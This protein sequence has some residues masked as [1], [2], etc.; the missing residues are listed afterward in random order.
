MDHHQRQ[1]SENTLVT[2]P[3]DDYPIRNEQEQQVTEVNCPITNEQ[4]QQTTE[5]SSSEDPAINQDILFSDIHFS[6][7]R[8]SY[9]NFEEVIIAFTSTRISM[10]E[11]EQ[12][13]NSTSFESA[14]P[15]A[16]S[17]SS[18]DVTNTVTVERPENSGAVPQPTS[19]CGNLTDTET[20]MDS[21]FNSE[22]EPQPFVPQEVQ[23]LENE[24]LRQGRQAGLPYSAV[25][26]SYN[27]SVGESALRGRWRA[28]RL[29]PHRRLRSPEWQAVDV[30]L[31]WHAIPFYTRVN[32]SVSWGGVAEY[33]FQHGGTY[34]F[35]SVDCARKWREIIGHV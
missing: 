12:R 13:N 10:A 17:S 20:S 18:R 29:P 14:Y 34:H 1:S 15:N 30:Q 23:S 28:I 27:F 4:E 32:G 2:S 24:I 16:N 6:T 26:A 35:G 31:L 22:S 11:V 3:E 25:R 33:I 7:E 5:D 9:T 8:H 21:M 19:E